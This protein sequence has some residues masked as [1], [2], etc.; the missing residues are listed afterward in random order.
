MYCVRHLR[1]AMKGGMCDDDGEDG[2]RKDI[3]GRNRDS[4]RDD[5]D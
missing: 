2:S 1:A 5:D 3:R 4:Y